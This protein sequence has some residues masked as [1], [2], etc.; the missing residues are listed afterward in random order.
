MNAT[1]T[2]LHAGL[3][4]FV[5]GILAGCS[6]PPPADGPNADQEAVATEDAALTAASAERG[7]ALFEQVCTECHTLTPPP[8]LAPPMMAVIGHYRAAFD[9]RD[10]AIEAMVAYIQSPDPERSRL[11]AMAVE[12]FGLMTA[13]TLP[14]E[15]LL[16]V[17]GW[18]WDSYDAE[19][20]PHATGGHGSHGSQGDG[21]D[22]MGRHRMMHSDSGG[23]HGGMHGDSAGEGMG[24]RHRMGADSAGD[25][26]GMRHR[27]EPESDSVSPK[28][29]NR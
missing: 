23:M 13:Q 7:E 2:A 22:G 8:N 5:I 28:T 1:R 15:D 19:L 12:R 24:M 9:D 11:G 16:A 6:E 29:S 4:S 14:E 27:R 18:L 20:D 21:A 3:A 25:G 10:Q 26:M 17:T